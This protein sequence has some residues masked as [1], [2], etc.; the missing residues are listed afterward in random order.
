[1]YEIGLKIIK[2]NLNR[3]L[4]IKMIKR[5]RLINSENKKITIDKMKS[6]IRNKK[7]FTISRFSYYFNDFEDF[8]RDVLYF[9]SNIEENITDYQIYYMVND[10]WEE[11][12]DIEYFFTLRYNIFKEMFNYHD[13]IYDK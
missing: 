12:D 10:T 4:S 8:E 6:D 9:I 2:S 3:D 5:L 13:Y 7:I 1:M 11:V